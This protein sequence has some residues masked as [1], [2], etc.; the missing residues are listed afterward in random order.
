MGCF[1]VPA[2]EAIVS[3][4]VGKSAKHSDFSKKLGWLTKLSAGGSVL[5]AFEHIW[6][7]EVS[8]FFPF[9]TAMNNAEDTAE[10]LHEISTTG[11]TMAV[12]VTAVWGVMLVVSR[13]IE[14]RAEK[15]TVQAD[16]A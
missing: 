11:V 1:L 4:V 9:L 14:R 16:E 12:A 2:G 13:I 5:L 10:M 15:D 8:P 3:G 6:H 7:G